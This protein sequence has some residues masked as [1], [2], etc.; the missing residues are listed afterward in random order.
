[1]QYTSV[2]I[3]PGVYAEYLYKF[4][5]LQYNLDM[6]Q[7][8]TSVNNLKEYEK[9][10]REQLTLWQNNDEAPDQ[11][12]KGT[13]GYEKPATHEMLD[14]PGIAHRLAQL[15]SAKRAYAIA[16]TVALYEIKMGIK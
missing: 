1:M 15:N 8:E 13:K 6:L 3:G 5:E 16:L 2:K 4:T 11:Q 12:L 7:S 9:N 10:Y 14:R